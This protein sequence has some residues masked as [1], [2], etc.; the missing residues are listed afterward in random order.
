MDIIQESRKKVDT[1][2]CL[3]GGSL[4]LS[5]CMFTFVSTKMC[6]PVSSCLL[7]YSQRGVQ[8]Q[9]T[10][11]LLHGSAGQHRMSTL[12]CVWP[13][14]KVTVLPDVSY[15]PAALTGPLRSLDSFPSLTFQ[16]YEGRSQ[17]KKKKNYRPLISRI[18]RDMG[19]PGQKRKTVLNDNQSYSWHS[20]KIP[21]IQQ[22]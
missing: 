7:S 3:Q 8:H 19:Q 13:K 2:L 11:S 12:T 4:E 10:I 22:V 9:N 17:A 20:R 18:H 6:I 16:N 5:I 1:G 15:Y 14:V 21:H